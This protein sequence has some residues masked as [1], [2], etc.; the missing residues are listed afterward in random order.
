VEEIRSAIERLLESQED[1]NRLGQQARR[2]AAEFS[3]D[4]TAAGTIGAL[5]K[6][7]AT[8]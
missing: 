4:H 3:W 7:A 2:R 6:I 5:E 8:T 1:R